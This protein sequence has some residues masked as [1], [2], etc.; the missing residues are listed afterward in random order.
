MARVFL[1]NPP[2]PEPVKTPLLAFCHLASALRVAGH[3]VALLDASAPHAPN[4]AM[5]IEAHIRAFAPDLVGLHLKTLQV[6]PAYALVPRLQAIA[7]LVAGGPHATICPDEPFAKGFSFVIRGEAEPTLPALADAL[8]GKQPFDGI[9]GLS[10]AGPL[11]PRHNPPR[12]FIRDLDALPSPVDAL[13]L[14][15]PLPADQVRIGELQDQAV[16]HAAGA[17]YAVRAARTRGGPKADTAPDDRC[18]RRGHAARVPHASTPRAAARRAVRHIGI[19]GP[20][21]SD[22]PAFPARYRQRPAARPYAGIRN[23]THQY[24]APLK[25]P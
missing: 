8:D 5:A 2:S 13:D 9:E 14:F 24:H 16:G 20:L 7:P 3:Q 12:D 1:L 18:D 10:F 11:G 15:K 19:D 25:A 21:H 17:A 6:Q 22:A 4:D 23:A